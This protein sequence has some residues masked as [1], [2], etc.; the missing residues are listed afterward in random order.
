MLHPV[1]RREVLGPVALAGDVVSP[2]DPQPTN[3]LTSLSVAGVF[4][5]GGF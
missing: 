5:P 1:L 3:E 4:N 2:N